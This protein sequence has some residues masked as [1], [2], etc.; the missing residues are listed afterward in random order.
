MS[1]C[2]LF[3][4][5]YAIKRIEQKTEYLLTQS[6][7]SLKIKFI[8]SFLEGRKQG[9]QYKDCFFHNLALHSFLFFSEPSLSFGLG[10]A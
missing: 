5:E 7:A 10:S 9:R 4:N 2:A 8:R 1:N 6:G 3:L